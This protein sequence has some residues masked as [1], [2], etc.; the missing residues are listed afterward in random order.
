MG[1]IPDLGVA[2]SQE[3]NTTRSVSPVKE[4]QKSEVQD[5]PDKKQEKKKKVVSYNLEV[6]LIDKINSIAS[7]KEMYY[8]SFVSMA[9]KS[10]LAR[11]NKS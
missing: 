1:F 8:S 5:Q 10:W 2:D 7:E 6:E 9:L 3:K 11:H 4:K